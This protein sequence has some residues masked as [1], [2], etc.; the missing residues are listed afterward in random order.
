MTHSPQFKIGDRVRVKQSDEAFPGE[1]GTVTSLNANSFVTAHGIGV[2]IDGD[3]LKTDSVF[4]RS[5][6]ELIE[7]D[8]KGAS[9]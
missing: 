8:P 6:L 3:P 5:R 9:K 1:F 7:P 4:P 2:L